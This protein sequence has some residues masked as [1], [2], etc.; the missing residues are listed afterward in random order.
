MSRAVRASLIY[1][2]VITV[3]WQIGM[4]VFVFRSPGSWDLLVPG[5]VLMVLGASVLWTRRRAKREK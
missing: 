3:F 2:L 5:I 1:G 4:I